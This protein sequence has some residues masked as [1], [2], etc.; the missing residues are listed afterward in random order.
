M[1]TALQSWREHRVDYRLPG[2]LAVLLFLLLGSLLPHDW[3]DLPWLGTPG[4]HRLPPREF[5]FAVDEGLQILD[6]EILAPAPIP[7]PRPAP[8]LAERVAPAPQT[9]SPSEEIGGRGEYSWDPTHAYRG[10][11]ELLVPE[12]GGTAADIDPLW[13]NLPYLLSMDGAASTTI[14]DTSQ[15]A[16]G[17]ENF[18]RIQRD[19]FAKNAPIWAYQ[20]A[21]ERYRELQQRLMS[22][23]PIRGSY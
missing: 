15:V 17:H 7:V 12:S 5:E 3:L 19:L 9:P 4:L 2:A 20:K 13:R 14:A 6:V 22:E 10:G 23:H 11:E 21:V 8:P 1:A 18:F 16:L